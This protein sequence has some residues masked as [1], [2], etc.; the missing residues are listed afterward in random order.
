MKHLSKTL[1]IEKW[2]VAELRKL[3]GRVFL[4]EVPPNQPAPFLFVA[5]AHEAY[6]V[7][8]Q[9]IE[10]VE[11]EYI[12]EVVES[13]YASARETQAKVLDVF[14]A[15]EEVAMHEGLRIE[16]VEVESATIGR[17]QESEEYIARLEVN[18][19]WN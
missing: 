17:V 3:G 2:I 9:D 12:V 4:A 15:M 1:I 10:S 6:Q 18:I 19:Y 11:S 16:L 7:E 13:G 14:N 8:T 5:L